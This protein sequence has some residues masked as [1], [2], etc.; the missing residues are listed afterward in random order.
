MLLILADAGPGALGKL[1]RFEQ[2][3][4]DIVLGAESAHEPI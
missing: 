2:S 3:K 1:L 4:T